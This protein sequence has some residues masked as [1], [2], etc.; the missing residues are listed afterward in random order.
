MFN[1]LKARQLTKHGE[2]WMNKPVFATLFIML[3][4]F[5]VVPACAEV[6][7]TV[8]SDDSLSVVYEFKNLDQSVYDEAKTRFAADTIPR[9]IA[10]N[11]ASQNRTVQWSVV[12]ATFFIDASR[13]IRNSFTLSGSGII[14]SSLNKTDLKQSYEV[15]TDWRK[16]RVDLTDSFSFDFSQNAAAPV[17]QWRKSNATTFYLENRATGT[18]DLQFYI[19]LPTSASEIQAASNTILYKM[20]ASLLDQFL[21]SPFPVL[22]ALAIALVIVLLYRRLR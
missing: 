4:V 6:S 9:I 3:T 22:A 8:R 12:D 11:M 17:E 16:F 14:S 1:A 18:L 20:P 10:D 7:V 5:L 19:V 2:R 21:Y 13:T 15:R